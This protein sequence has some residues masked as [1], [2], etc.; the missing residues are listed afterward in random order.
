MEKAIAGRQGS[1]G[2]AKGPLISICMPT[3][4]RTDF[5]KQALE[6]A[7]GQTY[8]NIEVFVS[9]D[10]P[11]DEVRS[12]VERYTSPKLRYQKNIPALGFV[13]KLN[14]FLAEA[15]GE[16]VVILCDD[17]V[18]SPEFVECIV[19]NAERYPQASMH[20]ARNALIDVNGKQ[21]R[22]DAPSPVVSSSSR[23][24]LDLYR[25]QAETFWVNLTGYAFRPQQLAA[26]GGFTELYAAR[27]AD[28][29]AWAALATVGPVICEERPLCKIRL[30]GSSVSSSIESGHADA[31]QATETAKSMVLGILSQV[32][33]NAISDVER[34]EVAA[35][36][37][38]LDR[39]TTEHISRALRHAL[40]A[41]L[42][43]EDSSEER[44]RQIW[45]RWREL[46]LPLSPVTRVILVA[47]I[48]PR[49]IRRPVVAAMIT[50]KRAYLH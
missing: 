11:G 40:V 23:F 6:S 47:S 31:V 32:E 17:D 10:T 48:L 1:S 7:L 18:L 14:S 20:R 45:L 42:A 8:P 38:M 25:P 36:R 35:A 34:K 33:T 27:H 5:L 37:E 12:I 41:E 16:W 21:V 2:S 9:D 4:K 24:L 13:P 28:R 19:S 15:K 43:K 49:A 22:L 50:Y 29:L 44:L 3:Y 26:L 39:Y 46:K 30:H